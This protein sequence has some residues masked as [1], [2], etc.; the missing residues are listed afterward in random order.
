MLARVLCA[1]LAAGSGLVAAGARPAAAPPL[2]VD[3]F[4]AGAGAPTYRIPALVLTGSGALVAFA[5]ARTGGDCAAKAVV[6]RRSADGGATW[7][8][9]QTVFAGTGAGGDSVGNPTAVWDAVSRRVVVA[10]ALG[11][12]TGG[13]NPGQSMFVVD[14]GGSDGA[15]WAA[16]R[17]VSAQVGAEWAGALPG[18]GTM[19][20]L[21]ATSAWPGRLIFP[22]HRG[23]YGTDVVI[24]S[25]DHGA[26]WTKAAARFDK[27]DEAVIAVSAADGALL[28]N[29]RNDHLTKCDCRAISRSS[30][31]G[32]TWSAISFDAALISPVCQ[33][34][35]V[36]IAGALFFS[37]PA[38]TTKRTNTTVRRS[39]DGGVTWLPQTFLAFGP[40]SA[41][42][43]SMASG[44]AI[45]IGGAQYGA[46]LYEATN[47]T[48]GAATVTF[49]LFPLDLQ[50]DEGAQM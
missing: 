1:C 30:D 16:P 47:A 25:D 39:N 3:V 24:L 32:S 35:L 6:S 48:S 11:S 5:E 42:Y 28:L 38:S 44:P 15:R 45:V 2:P 26:T 41:G 40:A 17:N 49:R 27:M 22:A 34:S 18:P 43:S 20:Q 14:D 29:M 7:A 13:C 4:T 9:P 10:L 31:G 12:S 36:N 37:N 46:I 21:P 33:G 50:Q 8:A 19:A 23:A